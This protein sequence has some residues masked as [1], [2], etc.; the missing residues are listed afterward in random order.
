MMRKLSWA[1]VIWLSLA[2]FCMAETWE[3]NLDAGPTS[4][5]GG[6]DYNRPLANGF[7]KAGLSGVYTDDDD[8]EYKWAEFSF[9]AG[10]DTIQPD[11]TCEVGLKCIIGDAEE[12]GR[13]GD[14]GALAF[15][16]QVGYLLPR[17]VIPIPLELFTGLTYSP[18]PLSFM[19]TEN[20]LSLDLGMGVHIIENAHVLLEY[21]AYEVDM[22]S[23]PG[24]WTLDDGVIRLGI[25]MR[26]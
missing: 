7:V 18:A 13:S 1:I 8:M 23:G 10:S 5:S 21:S 19:D 9:T 3:L 2:G 15:T 16:A 14:I 4:V 22:E 25:I 26:F 12:G 17:R 6:V 24:D 11:L 20:Y